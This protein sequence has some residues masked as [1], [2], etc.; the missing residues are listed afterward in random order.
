[1]IFQ[2]AIHHENMPF[3]WWTAIVSVIQMDLCLP[4]GGKISDITRTE[5]YWAF[6]PNVPS[7]TA[8]RWHAN[9]GSRCQVSQ[10]KR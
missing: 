3:L 7:A 8:C 1:M 9:P 4:D 2:D 6:D 5:G 10:V